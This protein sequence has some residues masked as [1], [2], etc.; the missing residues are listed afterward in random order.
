MRIVIAI[1]DLPAWTIPVTESRRIAA[2]LPAQDVVD[3]RDEP[4]RASAI[5]SA[6]V[7]FAA[8]LSASEFD[9]ATRLRWVHSPSVGVG[10][11]LSDALVNSAVVVSNS[12]GVHSEAIAEHAIALMLAL[13]RR[14]PMAVRRQGE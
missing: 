3:V 12:R 7:V 10:S 2:S 11:I 9:E 5:A 8:R 14:L 6:D 1:H 4:G 13:R